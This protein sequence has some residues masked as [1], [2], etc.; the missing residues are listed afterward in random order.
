MAVK[1]DDVDITSNIN[2]ITLDDTNKKISVN[3][4]DNEVISNCGTNE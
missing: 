4:D 3:I 1:K 2:W